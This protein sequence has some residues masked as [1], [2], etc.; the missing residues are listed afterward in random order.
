MRPLRYILVAG[1]SALGAL[2]AVGC[3]IAAL[4]EVQGFGGPRD[5]GP[6]SGYLVR[7]AVGF[8][9]CIAIPAFLS[10]RLLHVGAGWVAAAVAVSVAGV[11]VILGL[12]LSA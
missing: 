4:F 11:L 9:A 1:A 3:L 6:R 2:F 5:E 12:S 8:V 10:R 7:L